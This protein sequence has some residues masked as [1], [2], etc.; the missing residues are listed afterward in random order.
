[1]KDVLHWLN[2]VEFSFPPNTERSHALAKP[3]GFPPCSTEGCPALAKPSGFLPCCTDGCLAFGKPRGFF[4][5]FSAAL[6]DL[7]HYLPNHADILS[8]NAARSLTL[9]KTR[10]FYF[11]PRRKM[12]CPRQVKILYPSKVKILYPSKLKLVSSRVLTS[13]SNSTHQGRLPTLN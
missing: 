5:F 10:G 2:H 6:K 3:G 8:A 12:P 4:F 11:L 1:M 7:V 13:K 9:S